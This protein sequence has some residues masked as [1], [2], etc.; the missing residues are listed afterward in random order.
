MN[1][2]NYYLFQAV[3]GQLKHLGCVA[4]CMDNAP[5]GDDPEKPVCCAKGTIDSPC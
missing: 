3:E 4:L 2:K 1:I 5:E